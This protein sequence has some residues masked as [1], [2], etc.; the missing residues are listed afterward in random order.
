MEIKEDNPN[1]HVE[2]LSTTRTPLPM[3]GASIKLDGCNFGCEK[4]G[5]SI[6]GIPKEILAMENFNFFYLW[7]LMGGLC[8]TIVSCR[9]S[10]K[11]RQLKGNV[12]AHICSMA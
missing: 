8:L 3:P 12:W 9:I 6:C 10:V 2:N 1:Q 5:F 11:I 7:H 4:F